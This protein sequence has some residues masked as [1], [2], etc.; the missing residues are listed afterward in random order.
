VSEK[1]DLAAGEAQ[2]GD[3]QLQQLTVQ[4]DPVAEHDMRP[5]SEQKKPGISSNH[6]IINRKNGQ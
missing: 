4:L 5:G 1:L 6:K 3:V 2:R